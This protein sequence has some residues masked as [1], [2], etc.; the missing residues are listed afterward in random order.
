MIAFAIQFCIV[1]LAA[2]IVLSI[3]R[4]VRGPTL[5]DRILA[6]DLIATMAVGIIALLSM[7][8]RTADYIELILIYTLLGFSGATAFTF[9]LQ[10]AYDP[11]EESRPDPES[12]REDDA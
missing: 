11:H 4:V 1:G 6:F 2:G 12:A 3:V 8:W 5:L 7:Q 10:R 9:Y